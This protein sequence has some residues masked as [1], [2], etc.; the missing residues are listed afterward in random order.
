MMSAGLLRYRAR[1]GIRCGRPEDASWKE[2][3]PLRRQ[4]PEDVDHQWRLRKLVLPLGTNQSW[5][6]MP[7]QQGLYW[8]HRWKRYS[9]HH[10]WTQGTR[11]F[12][13]VHDSWLIVFDEFRKWTWVRG[14]RTPAVLLSRTCWSRRRTSWLAKALVSKLPWG[15]STWHGRL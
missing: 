10:P 5:S 13:K 11:S 7:R 14:L 4:W 6:K 15:R 8:L 1:C 3:R 12:M 2:R 9:R